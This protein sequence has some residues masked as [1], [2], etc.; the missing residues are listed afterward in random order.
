M[1]VTKP[2][3]RLFESWSLDLRDQVEDEVGQKVEEVENG[4]LEALLNLN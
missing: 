1:K 4:M 2:K 3:I